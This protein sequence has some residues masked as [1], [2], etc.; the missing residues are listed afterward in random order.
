MNKGINQEHSLFF[1]HVRHRRNS[2]QDRQAHHRVRIS[3]Q[4]TQPLRTGLLLLLLEESEKGDTRHL[5][6]LETNTGN[7]TL[8]VP[9][10]TETGHENLVVLIDEVEATIVGNESS[11]LLAVLDEL[12][13]NALAHSGVGLLGLDTAAKHRQIE[14]ASICQTESSPVQCGFISRVK[15]A[16]PD[17]QI[18]KVQNA[19]CHNLAAYSSL[20]SA[21]RGMRHN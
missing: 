1:G 19:L 16:H 10:A 2:G 7:V 11:N 15:C 4:A 21:P 6:D 13:T 3:G 17:T 12:H 8:G 18:I 5:G 14:G 9:T 20:L